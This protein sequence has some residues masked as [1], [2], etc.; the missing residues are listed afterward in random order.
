MRRPISVGEVEFKERNI[1]RRNAKASFCWFEYVSALV[2]QKNRVS[3]SFG[4]E[5][6]RFK[7][8]DKRRVTAFS[9]E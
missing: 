2:F 5:E 4:G 8:T 1:P 3:F 7:E 6:T 9:E